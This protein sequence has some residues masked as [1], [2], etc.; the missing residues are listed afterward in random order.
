MNKDREY[1]LANKE[2]LLLKQKEYRKRRMSN[3]ET[4]AHVREMERKKAARLRA[5]NPAKF[6]KIN[7]E[8]WYA[9]RNAWLA[10][11]GPCVKC[12]STERLELDHKDPATKIDHKVWTWSP[13]RRDVELAKCQVLCFICHRL[14][15]NEERGWKLHGELM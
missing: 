2:T 12:G 3:P 10:E 13:T 15:T 14:K 9:A 8:R 11:H 4:A 5:K 6:R 1:Y 7:M